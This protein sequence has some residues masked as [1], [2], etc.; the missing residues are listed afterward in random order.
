M[1]IAPA[2]TSSFDVARASSAAAAPVFGMSTEDPGVLPYHQE[3]QMTFGD[4]LDIINPLQHIPLV[5]TLYREVTGDTISQQSRVMGGFLYG[6]P[7]GGMGAVVNVMVEDAT[8]KDIGDQLLSAMSGDSGAPAAQRLSSQPIPL[9]PQGEAAQ[10]LA[11]QQA[12]QQT[13]AVPVQGQ[14]AAP[15]PASAPAAAPAAGPVSAR[16]AIPVQAAQ[17]PPAPHGAGLATS[18]L[19]ARNNAAPL[20]AERS[21]ELQEQLLNGQYHPS[22]MP[23]RDAVPASTVQAKHA[24]SLAAR[25]WASQGGSVPPSIAVAAAGGDK[26]TAAG[27]ARAVPPAH[28]IPSPSAAASAATAAS[29]NAALAAA[30]AAAQPAASTAPAGAPPAPAA[31]AAQ[32]QPAAPA[33]VA[34]EM[35]SDVMMRNLAKYEA[36]KKALNP[37]TPVIRT[38]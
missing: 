16:T 25:Q 33:P 31:G 35:L 37:T 2:A 38:N 10:K 27:T 21:Q 3:G 22:R 14:A 32:Q 24:A 1:A 28:R 23:T 4:F 9:T 11:A 18:A 7:L 20:S 29:A 19:M 26:G 30:A 15:P 17:A 12:A 34:P 13:A 6:G 36:A 5:S 8:G